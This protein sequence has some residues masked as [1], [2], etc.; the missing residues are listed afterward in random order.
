MDDFV[1]YFRYIK[2]KLPQRGPDV[3]PKLLKHVVVALIDDGVDIPHHESAAHRFSGESFHAYEY[4]RRV[5][6][7]WNSAAGHGTLMAR[8]IHRICPNAALYIIKLETQT[9]EADDTK[10]HVVPESAIKVCFHFIS[11]P[12]LYVPIHL[13]NFFILSSR[14]GNTGLTH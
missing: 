14:F 7:W 6:P 11:Q 2:P 13:S 8:L 1:R 9:T 5:W 4:G 10:I 3:P 12:S